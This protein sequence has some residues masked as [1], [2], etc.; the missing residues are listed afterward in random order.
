MFFLRPSIFSGHPELIVAQSTRHGGVSP[1]PYASLNLGKSTGDDPA[2]VAEN[3]RLFASA[4]G[5]N[6]NQLVFSKQVHG[7]EVLEA[8]EP[9]LYAGYDAI[10]SDV[11]GLVLAVS[12][13]D[14]AP[15]LMYD[16]LHQAVAAIHA[17]W[18]GMAGGI[19]GHALARMKALYGTAGADCLAYI[20]PC[21]DECSFEVGDEV[22]AQFEPAFKRFS[23]ESGKYFVDLK[24]AGAAQLQQFGIPA[25]QIEISPLSTVTDNRDFFSHRLEKGTTGRMMAVIGV[26]IRH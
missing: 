4:V 25:G 24:K 12:V 9:G 15:I 18:R 16:T 21:I 13:A 6:L 5:F 7:C 2:H 20:G 22:A 26:A 11:P 23:T 14:C 17:G 8:A 1:A 10:V 3:R 19:I